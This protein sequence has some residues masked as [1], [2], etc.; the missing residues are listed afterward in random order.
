[1]SAHKDLPPAASKLD[2]FEDAPPDD[3]GDVLAVNGK[4]GHHKEALPAEPPIYWPSLEG[5]PPPRTWWIQDWLGPWP[6][7]T[8][9]AGGAGKTRL[10]QAVAT[11]LATGRPYI[12][13]QVKPLR[14][15]TWLCEESKDE[16]W[17]NQVAINRHFTLSMENLSNLSIV[18]RQGLDNT[19]LAI[20]Y[21]Q[22][23][24]TPLIE[25]LRQQVNDL[26]VDV[27]VLDNLAQLFG[28]NENDRHQATFFVN[29]ISG[30]VRD[31]P[32]S[33]VFVGHTARAQGSEYSG[34]AAW[35]N[36]V[37]MRWY[38][39]STLPD[40]KPTDED[41]PI[42]SDTVYLARRKANYAPKDWMRLKYES[43]VLVP[44]GSS[45][46]PADHAFR[47]GVA[48]D[49]IIAAIVKLKSAGIH[50]TDG[51]TSSDY[52]PKQIVSKRLAEGHSKREL[53][54]A[55]NRLMGIGRLRR[56]I[57]GKY[58]NRSPRYGLVIV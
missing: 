7:L 24:F 29:A 23:Q 33:P 9:G 46:A 1:V 18:P 55:M 58:S 52:L 41:E 39:G 57:V 49:L 44:E 8:S 22:P 43:G 27:L 34:S 56:D 42:D 5:E 12:G 16:V 37:R 47:D 19:L 38:V 50:P 10:W 14:V 13:A 40:Q 28:G 25:Q 30:L 31:R 36:A 26:K 6:T 11:S 15:L 32:F 45:E 4:N 35:E 21:G 2:D 3:Y 17:R 51:I 54:A 20:V 53:A 48:D